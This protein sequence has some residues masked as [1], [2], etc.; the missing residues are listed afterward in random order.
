VS[1]TRSQPDRQAIAEHLAALHQCA[2]EAH[3]VLVLASFGEDPMTGTALAPLVEHVAIGDVEKMTDCAMEWSAHPH[4]N[5][6]A[7]LVVMRADLAPGNKGGE[8]DIVAGLGLVADFDDADAIQWPTRSPITPTAI[9]ETSPGRFQL[10]YLFSAPMDPVTAKGLARRLQ[11]HTGCDFGT[12]DL[13]HVWRI[14]G[15]LNWPNKRKLD[16]GRSPDPS[17]VV[18][19]PGGSSAV[20]DATALDTALP[21]LPPPVNNTTS[22]RPAQPVEADDRTLLDRMLHASNGAK[23]QALWDGDWKGAG[24]PSQSEADS[25]L[26]FH[27]A[28]Y[29]GRDAS[30]VDRLFRQSALFRDKWDTRRGDS[31]YGADT[32]AQACAGCTGTYRE[33]RPAKPEE[34]SPDGPDAPPVEPTDGTNEHAPQ[35]L[36]ELDGDIGDL[37]EI[38]RRAWAAIHTGNTPPLLFLYGSAPSRIEK[39]DEEQQLRLVPLT[40]DRLRFHAAKLARWTKLKPVPFTKKADWRRVECR[41]PMDV[42]FNMLAAPEI[43]LPILSRIVEVPVFAAGGTLVQRPGYDAKAQLYYQPYDAAITVSIPTDP[44]PA[45]LAT[46]KARLDDVLSDFPFVSQADRTHAI[47]LA[48]VPFVRDLIDGPTPLH[49]AEAASPGSGKNLLVEAVLSPSVGRRIGVIAEA[50]EDDEWRK[51]LTARLREGYPI[52][53]IDNLSRPLDSGTVSTVL[54]ARRWEDRLLGKNETI[55]IP[56]RT[57]FVCTANNP[58]LSMEIARRAIRIRLDPKMDRPWLREGFR[59]ADLRAFVEQERPALIVAVLTLVQGWLQAGRPQPAAKPLGAFE[60]WSTIVGGIVEFAGYPHFLGNALE[61]YEAAD[62]EGQI[63]RLFVSS[64]WDTYRDRTVSAKDLFDIAVGLDGFSFGRASSEQGQR[65]VLGHSL[66]KHRD[67]IVGDFRIELAGTYGSGAQW[68][69]QPVAVSP[70]EAEPVENI[71]LL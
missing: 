51:R 20:I 35:D 3:G 46:A 58:V 41:P 54:T 2:A 57:I 42:I 5:V 47:A 67:Q 28:F 13:S 68:R 60:S 66:K 8:T 34:A 10:V 11:A 25:A 56:V 15:T 24:Y 45:D 7:P 1:T 69:L 22:H 9:L 44:T 16:A 52:T 30:R 27:L 62:S 12:K 43:P 32:I 37:D 17:L 55:A 31:T 53:L 36:L 59:H 6:Y 49:V 23:I 61:F 38:T 70:P 39:D 65:T 63:W 48:V 71:T 64:W 40:P 29:C 19:V 14:S 33:S 21:V 18:E 4:R 50:R 26:A